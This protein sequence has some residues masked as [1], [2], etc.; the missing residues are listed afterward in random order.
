MADP[1]DSLPPLVR[2]VLDEPVVTF[3][4]MDEV[5]KFVRERRREYRVQSEWTY[6]NYD[7]PVPD[8]Y[9]HTGSFVA[10][11]SAGLTCFPEKEHAK[12]MTA[13]SAM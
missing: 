6:A 12:P 9:Q 11:P 13:E 3:D 7:Y 1:R 10:V 4:N 8:Q 2:L 5:K